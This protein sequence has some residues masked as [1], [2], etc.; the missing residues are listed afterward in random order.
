M[1]QILGR[2]SKS[3]D[4]EPFAA[5]SEGA[6]EGGLGGFSVTMIKKGSSRRKPATGEVVVCHYEGRLQD[7]TV[8]DSSRQR[9]KPLNFV[10][11]IGSVIKAWD[12]GVAQMELGER[13]C[14]IAPPEY[15]YGEDG[16]GLVPGGSTLV[17][18][19]ELLKIADE[20]ARGGNCV[21]S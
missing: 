8:F 6:M 16:G 10:I 4:A 20:A 5:L 17:F 11:G 13:A 19:V 12:E 14:I 9:N 7:G 2:H 21:V 1:G 3:G 18:D 15:G